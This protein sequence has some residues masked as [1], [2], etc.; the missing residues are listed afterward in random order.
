MLN[1]CIT[2]K[3]N[4]TNKQDYSVLKE[5]KLY[6]IK[7]KNLGTIRHFKFISETDE[8]IKGFYLNK[9]LNINKNDIIK[10]NKFSLGKTAALVMPPIFII[11]TLTFLN[12]FSNWEYNK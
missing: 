9:E 7:T 8:N 4:S 3:V 5:N 11:A 1:S 12:S 10:I 6:I 2:T